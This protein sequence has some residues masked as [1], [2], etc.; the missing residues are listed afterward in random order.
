MRLAQPI[1][2]RPAKPSLNP[3][4][5]TIR[6]YSASLPSTFSALVPAGFNPRSTPHCGGFRLENSHWRTHQSVLSDPADAPPYR[7]NPLLLRPQPR[8]SRP[9][10]AHVRPAAAPLQRPASRSQARSP[11]GRPTPPDDAR[12]E[13]RPARPVQRHRRLPHAAHHSPARRR[14]RRRNRRRQPRSRQSH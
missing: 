14:Q 5:G 2:H 11:R 8:A 6:D 12:R 7:S 1:A 3:S 9:L 4:K 13:N 10:P